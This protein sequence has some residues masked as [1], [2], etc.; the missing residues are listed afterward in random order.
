MSVVLTRRSRRYQTV[1]KAWEP[2]IRN[3]YRGLVICSTSDIL[4]FN[5]TLF[6][7]QR[8]ERFDTKE[9]QIIIEDI[10]ISGQRRRVASVGFNFGNYG[11]AQSTVPTRHEISKLRLQT[12]SK[13]VDEAHITFT[14]TCQFLKEGSAT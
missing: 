11:D 3:P 4:E 2:T 1:P 9:Y 10:S 8:E 13:K 14:L 6:R 5:V 7:D 12:P